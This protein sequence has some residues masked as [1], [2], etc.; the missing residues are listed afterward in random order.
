[1]QPAG[2]VPFARPRFTFNQNW[3]FAEGSALGRIAELSDGITFSEKGIE[4]VAAQTAG[5]REMGA[6]IPLI[7]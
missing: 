3:T 6:M 5:L 1:M 7:V 2:H 4:E